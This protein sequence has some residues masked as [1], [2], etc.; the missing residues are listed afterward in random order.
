MSHETTH[1]TSFAVAGSMVKIRFCRR[2]I[3]P[4]RVG[5]FLALESGAQEEMRGLGRLGCARALGA[6]KQPPTRSLAGPPGRSGPPEAWQRRILHGPGF[7]T[8]LLHSLHLVSAWLHGALKPLDTW[9]GTCKRF[10][11]SNITKYLKDRY[12]LL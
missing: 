11:I 5:P 7:R 8:L 3:L 2:S 10:T 4:P 12:F 9:D 1:R 6:W